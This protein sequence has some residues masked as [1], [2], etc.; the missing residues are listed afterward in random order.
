MKDPSIK[1]PRYKPV[2]LPE[3][4]W[5]NR[6]ITHAPLWCSVDLRDG[7]QALPIPMNLEEKLDLFNLL[8]EIGFKEIEAGYP[9]SSDTEYAFIRHLVDHNLIPEDI[10]IQVVTPCIEGFIDKTFQAIDGAQSVIFH[11]LNSTS[12]MQRRQVYNN[13]E[14]ATV[15]LAVNAAKHIRR[16]RDEA[17]KKGMKLTFEYSPESFTETEPEFAVRIVEEVLDALDAE[18]SRP[19][20]IN[21][22]AT[23]EKCLPNQYADLIEWFGQ[24][25]KDRSRFIL[26]VHPHNDRGSAVAA[27]ELAILAGA[28]RIEGTLFGNGE[29]TGNVDLVTLALNLYTQGITPGLDL[30]D[31]DRIHDVYQATTHQPVSP[32]QPYAGE[33]VYTAFSGAHQDAILK[34][35][36]HRKKRRL[37][38]WQI[39]Y[40]PLDPAD[41]GRLYE[42]I[43]RINSQSGKSGASFVLETRYGYKIP[44]AMLPELG[45][46]VKE[47][48]DRGNKEISGESLLKIFNDEFIRVE[49]PYE[50]KSFNTTYLH[51]EDAEDNEVLLKG[52][53]NYNGRP[54]EV[55]GKGNGPI[56]AMYDAL[57]KIGAADYDFL[58]YDQHALSTGSDSRA[59]AYIQLRNKEGQT[60]FG[61]G[62][63]RD[64]RK[65]SLRALIS[66]INRIRR[67]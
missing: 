14:D 32:R 7:N 8:V 37:E 20:I 10:T 24:N 56:D 33:L 17:E 1:Y 3:R 19:A 49:T 30:S 13:D 31:I 62:T 34:V 67:L 57:K 28:Q 53:I 63:S 59:I 64:T 15:A 12:P 54:T 36:D 50:L 26:S 38:N 18:T 51:E 11:F 22:P 55:E 58:S 16:L 40:L 35:I 66:A 29:R 27:A 42:P 5:P 60:C 44:K 43:I 47:A 21:L 65:A 9:A 23:V 61:V 46:I 25:V 2:D 52:I 4:V 45:Q 39:P 48:A 41:V 6:L